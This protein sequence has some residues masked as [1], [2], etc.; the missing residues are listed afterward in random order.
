MPSIRPLVPLLIAAGILLAGNGVQGTLIA[1]RGAEEGFSAGLIGL[2][3]TAYFGGF[4]LGCLYIARILRNVG[5]IRT[6]SALAALA[7]AVSLILVLVP[8]GTVWLAVR[9][10]SGFCFSGL[11]TT[12]ESWLN[13]GVSNENR[14]RVLSVYRIIDIAAVTGSQ[15]LIPAVGSGGFAIF[16]I[17]SMMI[18]LSLVPVSLAD[19]SSPKAPEDIKLDLAGVWRISPIAAIGCIAIGITNSS[20]RMIGPIYV[21]ETGFGIAEVATFMSAGIVGGIVLQYPLG[22]LSDRWDRRHVLMLST[23]GAVISALAISS[24]AGNSLA[25]NLAGVLAFGAFAM[26]L[27]S[28]SAAH[29]NDHAVKGNYVQV[30]AGLMLFYSVGAM[31]GPPAAAT[32]MEMFGPR[33]LFVFIS[34]VHA[35]L[36]VATAWRLHMRAPVPA[37]RRG[38][39]TVLLR[40][41]PVIARLA[42]AGQTRKQGSGKQS[43]NH[44][45]A[46]KD[47]TS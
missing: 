12:T 47:L 37:E 29:A 23:S 24:F 16:A 20:F 6:F 2:M 3:G 45:D 10:I 41:S 19:R 17:V 18:S 44:G 27:Y 7:S 42:R 21:Q 9:F 40:T 30:A 33:A 26:P 11:F 8:D 22:W 31:A 4:L 25:L 39:F 36:F 35:S 5:H 13:S 34:V 14:G 28:L 38:R 1:V 15:Y 43:T 32:L 46:A